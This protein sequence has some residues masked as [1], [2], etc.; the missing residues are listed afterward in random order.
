[1]KLADR[2]W[3]SGEKFEKTSWLPICEA[4]SCGNNLSMCWFVA[5]F[6]RIIFGDKVQ[7][8]SLLPILKD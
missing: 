6:V 5:C 3:S 4:T 2:S 8:A 7:N 1:M